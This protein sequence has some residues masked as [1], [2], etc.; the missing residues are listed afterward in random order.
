MVGRVAIELD[1]GRSPAQITDA[2]AI[3]TAAP[4]TEVAQF[5]WAVQAGLAEKYKR[6][7]I[8]GSLWFFGGG[9]VTLA[10]YAASSG[11]GFF[12][13]FWGAMLWGAIDFFRGLTGWWKYKG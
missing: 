7:M 6:H 3:E 2:L 4:R 13:V 8:Y 12:V 5:V 9:I 10:T 11:G 1:K